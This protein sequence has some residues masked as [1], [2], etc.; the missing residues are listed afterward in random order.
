MFDQM[1][2]LQVESCEGMHELW[3]HCLIMA[4]IR[5]KMVMNVL[6]G[7]LIACVIA[8][9]I[10]NGEIQIGKVQLSQYTVFKNQR[11]HY[12]ISLCPFRD[13]IWHI[14]SGDVPRQEMHVKIMPSYFN[15]LK[16]SDE[17]FFSQA[18]G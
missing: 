4:H 14:K 10:F 13:L 16:T 7:Y 2:N 8:L 6:C 18:L 12:C 11:M 17:V 9:F 3:S 1:V 5:F 15:L